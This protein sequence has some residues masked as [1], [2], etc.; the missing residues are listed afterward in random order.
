MIGFFPKLYPDELLYSAF[1]RY[2]DKS[3]YI[4][5]T[6]AAEDL[7]ENKLVRPDAEFIN[8]LSSD[9]FKIITDTMPIEDII[10]HHTMFPYYVR[11]LDLSRRKRAFDALTSMQTNFRYMLAIPKNKSGDERFLRYCPVCAQN[12]RELFGETYWHRIHQMIGVR[13]CPIHF[14]ALNNSSVLISG[15]ASPA[16]IS[17]ES[18]IGKDL[19]TEFSD[20]EVERKLAKYISDVF[21]SEVNMESSVPMG[22]FL[23]SKMYGTPYVSRRGEQRNISKIHS[24][25]SSFYHDLPNDYFTEPWQLQKV[26]TNCYL[27]SYEICRVAMFLDI[28]VEDLIS[29]ELPKESQ[30]QLFDNSVVQMHEQG[31]SYPKIADKLNASICTVKTS[32]LRKQTTHRRRKTSKTKTGMKKQNWDEVDKATLPLVINAIEDI[33]GGEGV[34]PKKITIATIER[35]LEL[36]NK[37]ISDCLPKC[38]AEI[39]QY[40]ESYEQYWARE[41]VWAINKINKEG[42]T[43]N[44][45]QI[46]NL[47]NMRKDNIIACLPYLSTEIADIIRSIIQL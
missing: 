25:F 14:Y 20:I 5:Y 21:Q 19:R 6:F 26:F 38:K 31:M 44:W 42:S 37:R 47:T 12:D 35:A 4:A 41:V 18:E 43:L 17:A 13:I 36:P 34:R 3:G 32:G 45:K 1:A 39:K 9:A 23:H 8:R 16:L 46:R 29:M 11:F 24:D 22:N 15:K 27:S 40:E 10:T 30:M 2:Y 33:R 28:S 7:Y